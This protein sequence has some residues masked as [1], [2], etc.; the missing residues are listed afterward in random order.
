VPKIP[1]EGRNRGEQTTAHQSPGRLRTHDRK[2]PP[3]ISHGL[4]GRPLRKSVSRRSS[5]VSQSRM[6][7]AGFDD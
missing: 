4:P 1:V 7:I 2:K 6:S 3:P 5:V